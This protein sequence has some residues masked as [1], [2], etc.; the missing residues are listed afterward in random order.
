MGNKLT[1]AQER[2]RQMI[3]RDVNRSGGDDTW[4]HLHSHGHHFKQVEACV[5]RGDLDSIGP[6]RYRL[7]DAGRAA[8]TK[9]EAQAE[10]TALRARLAEVEGA[11]AKLNRKA[12]DRLYMMHAYRSL[13]GP[14]ALK[15]IE[16]W[17]AKGVQRIHHDWGP[18]AATLTGE[19]RA[20]ILTD[21]EDQVDVQKTARRALSTAKE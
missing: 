3:L 1:K 12:T 5:R 17:E 13:V 11:L 15:L 20:Q 18:D 19:E 8:L 16:R 7:T 21:T 4:S 6:Y 9:S 2:A 10:I 14:I